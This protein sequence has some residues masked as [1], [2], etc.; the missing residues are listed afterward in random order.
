MWRPSSY[1]CMFGY[2][3]K[4]QPQRLAF[5]LLARADHA[6]KRGFARD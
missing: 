2:K 1:E 6:R 3:L 4:S 5:L